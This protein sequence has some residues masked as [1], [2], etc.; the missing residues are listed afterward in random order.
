MSQPAL[1]YK[2][3]QISNR[4][5]I[6][7]EKRG[8]IYTISENKTSGKKKGDKAFPL[9]TLEEI[10]AVI[11][12]YENKA[13]NENTRYRQLADRNKLLLIWRILFNSGTMF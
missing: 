8:N 6:K 13:N 2:N 4:K 12:Y 1:A 7:V 9:K 11:E 10:S 5:N 3:S